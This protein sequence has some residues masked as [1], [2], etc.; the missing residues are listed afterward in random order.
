ME[1]LRSFETSIHIRTIPDDDNLQET[2]S[3]VPDIHNN[4]T[5]N[6]ED[7]GDTFLRNDRSHTDYMVL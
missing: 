4:L 1:V 2:P 7:A 3:Y 6:P 5:V